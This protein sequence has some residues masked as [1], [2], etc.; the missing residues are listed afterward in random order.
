MDFSILKSAYLESEIYIKD[1]TF[2]ANNLALVVT[3]LVPP[4]NTYTL[5]PVPYVTTENYVR[6]LSQSSYL[7]A[8]YIIK[9][10]LIPIDISLNVFEQAVKK[11]ELYYR[12]LSMTFHKR[13]KRN[14][15]FKMELILKN[16]REIKRLQDF[17]L[18][19]FTNKRTV[20]SGEMSFIFI[21]Q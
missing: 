21:N 7:L 17:I 15:S 12:N 18:F 13:V 1:I 9:N 6:C 10:G 14:E 20:I 19:T 5:N 4:S 16:F 3:C 11:Y 2:N 8:N